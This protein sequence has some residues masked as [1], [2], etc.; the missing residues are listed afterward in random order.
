[1]GS[2]RRRGGQRGP[3]AGGPRLG[4]EHP[5]R[6]T[7]E[8]C[9]RKRQKWMSSLRGERKRDVPIAAKSP[10]TGPLDRGSG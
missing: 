7:V 3:G 8:S 1:M 5:I 6:E 9:R 4:A 2:C 10:E